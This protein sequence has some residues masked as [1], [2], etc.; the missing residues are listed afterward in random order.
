[1]TTLAAGAPAPSLT[2]PNQDGTVVDLNDLRGSTVV[3]YFYPA[4]FTPGCT[5]QACDFRDNLASLKSA[6]VV[7][8][9]VSADDP[10]KLREFSDEYQLNF[11]LLS[12]D[13]AATAKAWGAW[14]PKQVNGKDMVGT[15]RS[16]VIVDADGVVSA[17]DY[18]VPA[19]GSVSA[20]RDRLGL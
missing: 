16:T 10:A 1:M 2:L 14:G 15:L 18:N 20:V 7:V 6:G 9:G 8:L 5:T 12:D 19:D 3:V 17:A 4:A 11:D 13:G